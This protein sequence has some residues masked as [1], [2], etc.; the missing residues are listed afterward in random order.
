V[1]E[2]EDLEAI[3]HPEGPYPDMLPLPKGWEK[4]FWGA[5]MPN[6][7]AWIRESRAGH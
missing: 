5:P 1:I 3:V 6:V 4:T 7:A 2:E